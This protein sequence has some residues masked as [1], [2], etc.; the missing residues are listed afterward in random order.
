MAYILTGKSSFGKLR[1]NTLYKIAMLLL[2]NSCNIYLFDLVRLESSLSIT[3]SVCLHMFSFTTTIPPGFK[4]VLHRWKNEIASSTH[5]PQAEL[6]LRS[7]CQTEGCQCRTAMDEGDQ[8]GWWHKTLWLVWG[9]TYHLSDIAKPTESI[10]HHTCMQFISSFCNWRA[11]FQQVP[12]LS[13]NV[14]TSTDTCGCYKGR[15]E[16]H[17]QH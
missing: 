13:A 14:C 11:I 1:C 2:A 6:T 4:P 17:K 10:W 12:M 15:T 3:N 5:T 9:D 16:Q 7:I 8:Q